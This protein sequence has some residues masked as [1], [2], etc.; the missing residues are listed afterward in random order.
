MKQQKWFESEVV[1]V[2]DVVIFTKVDS[3]V[4]KVYTYGMIVD[5]EYGK[6]GLPRKAKIRY[7]NSSEETF[8]ETFRA[9]RG[10][11]VIHRA[12]ESDIMTELGR[13]AKDID[14]IDSRK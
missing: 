14:F 3:I 13:M 2:G 4:S 5:L 7:K 9:V 12:D 8:R 11:V 6:D 1:N 10:L